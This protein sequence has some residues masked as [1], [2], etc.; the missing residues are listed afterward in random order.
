MIRALMI[1]LATASPGWALTLPDLAGRW[2]G[3]GGYVI[4]TEPPQRLRCQMRGT[5][6]AR[7]VALVGRCATAQGGQSFAWTLTDLGDGTIRAEDSGPPSDPPATPL[8]G[9]IDATGLRFA[10]PDGGV[11]DL[12]R[13]ADGLVLRLRGTD[14]DRPVQAEARLRPEG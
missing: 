6:T 2:R 5:P 9:R 13:D 12:S 14:A 11:F 1:L 4:G 3:E 7:G 10:A 8:S